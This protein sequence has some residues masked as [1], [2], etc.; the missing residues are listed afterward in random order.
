MMMMRDSGGGFCANVL[1]CI[2][3]D[4]WCVLAN[5]WEFC[6]RLKF[7]D[8]RE[9]YTLCRSWFHLRQ[10]SRNYYEDDEGQVLA[11]GWRCRGELTDCV[12]CGCGIV[13]LVSFRL[14]LVQLTLSIC[15]SV[16]Q[17]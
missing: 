2:L 6:W 17:Q 11:V 13:F 1:I 16:L 3:E 4:D 12:R 5:F 7:C 9:N 14:L 15:I 8:E 10:T